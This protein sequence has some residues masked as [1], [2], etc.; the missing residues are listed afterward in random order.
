VPPGIP[1]I[2]INKVMAF[3]L[4]TYYAFDR[5]FE[6]GGESIKLGLFGVQLSKL[7]VHQSKE[8]DANTGLIKNKVLALYLLE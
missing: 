8:Q 4:T 2:H 7:L 6:N 3:A 1:Q 5:Y